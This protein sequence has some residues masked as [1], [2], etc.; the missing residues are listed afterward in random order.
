MVKENRSRVLCFF[1]ESRWLIV[2][3]LIVKHDFSTRV[4]F[5]PQPGDLCMFHPHA[6]KCVRR[7][8]VGSNK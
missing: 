1:E 8:Y 2:W 6:S 3:L 5:L 7:T 4:P